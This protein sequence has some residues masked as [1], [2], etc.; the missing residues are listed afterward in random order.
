MFQHYIPVPTDIAKILEASGTKR[1]IATIN[2]F[3]IRRAL[4]GSGD[5][6]RFIVTS[7]V[8][9]REIKASPGDVVHVE[10]ISDPEPDRIDLGE[11]FETVLAQDSDAA[12]RFFNMTT[13]RQRGLAQYITSAKRVETRIK[14]ALEIA[15]KLR[16][17][18]L[19]EDLK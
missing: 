16:T 5:G 12:E 13:G 10:M 11:E 4:F 18:T 6:E 1:V 8:F 17:D 3:S 19:H 2:G 14:R 7:R 15:L 9:L